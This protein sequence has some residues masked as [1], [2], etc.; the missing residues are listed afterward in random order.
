MKKVLLLVCVGAILGCSGKSQN[1]ASKASA[2]PVVQA[3]SAPSNPLPLAE[4]VAAMPAVTAGSNHQG[5]HSENV[6]DRFGNA[7]ALKQT[8][9]DGQF[10]L[11]IVLRGTHAFLSFAKHGQWE[12]VYPRAAKG[13]LMNLRLR[14]EDG[15]ERCVVWDELGFGTNNVYSVVWSFPV[16]TQF[17][18]GPVVGSNSDSVGGDEQLIQELMKHTAM[19]LEVAPGATTQF[20][21]AGLARDTL[22]ARASKAEPPLAARQTEAE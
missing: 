10:D 17:S 14:F 15:Q 19:L 6:K 21:I 4:P 2:L 20:D 1:A 9:L 13:K 22:K 7:V 12:S 11:V 18:V 5:W 3:S 16:T 8:S